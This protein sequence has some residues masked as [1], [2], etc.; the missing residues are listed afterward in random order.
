[1]LKKKLWILIPLM[2][3]TTL[4]AKDTTVTVVV[5]DHLK[6]TSTQIQVKGTLFDSTAG[7]WVGTRSGIDGLPT[8]QVIYDPP[9]LRNRRVLQTTDTPP[10]WP[11]RIAFR[12][13]QQWYDTTFSHRCSGILVGPKYALTAAH[14]VN[15]RASESIQ[16]GWLYD[17]MFVRPGYDRGHD[18]PSSSVQGGRIA[19]VRVVRSW[20]PRTVFKY[21]DEYGFIY[22]GDDDWAIMELDRDVGTELGWAAVGPMK[23]GIEVNGKK[24]HILSYPWR[25]QCSDGEFCDTVPRS[26]SLSHSYGTVTYSL[27]DP[28][29]T[30]FKEVWCPLVLSWFGESGSGFLDCPDNNCKSGKMT[31]RGTRW[32]E[33]TISSVD[34][35]MSGV[36][37]EIL[38]DVKIPSSVEPRNLAPSF[39]LRAAGGFLQAEAIRDGEWQIL[40]LDGRAIGAPTFGRNLSV[41]LDR[42][43][44]GV[45]LVVFREPGQVP[46]T[47]RWVGR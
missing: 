6:Q 3:F 1:M 44:R 10:G 36:I 23:P 28:S 31:V 33:N 29:G 42:L 18:L 43:P 15:S 25:P 45:A 32:R 17:S 34:S 16:D 41:P 27:W 12:L 5:R 38:K 26:D 24:F 47:R 8:P 20:V 22:A 4:C 37:A 30:N 39:E 21:A 2:G 40:S 9:T 11:G 14:C 35:T 46:V 13:D 19:P 7:S